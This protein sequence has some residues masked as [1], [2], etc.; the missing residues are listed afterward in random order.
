MTSRAIALYGWF[1]HTLWEKGT[2]RFFPIE[3][4]ERGTNRK[5]WNQATTYAETK[6]KHRTGSEI[7]AVVRMQTKKLRV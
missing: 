4:H 6:K 1:N 2:L 3:L 5:Y 7:H